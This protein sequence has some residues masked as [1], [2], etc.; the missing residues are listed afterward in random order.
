M[1][2]ALQDLCLDVL[3]S[4][5]ESSFPWTRFLTSAHQICLSLKSKFLLSLISVILKKN[6]ELWHSFLHLPTKRE[7]CPTI[8]LVSSRQHMTH[9]CGYTL[10][11]NVRTFLLVISS[12]LDVCLSAETSPGRCWLKEQ[13]VIPYRRMR[14]FA[15][16]STTSAFSICSLIKSK[17][18]YYLLYSR[19]YWFSQNI[20]VSVL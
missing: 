9:Q 12:G 6:Q 2:R 5:S 7:N 3:V 8:S 10:S 16:V 19:N 11:P 15:S 13:W 20:F 17:C 14:W 18:I 4:N 1:V